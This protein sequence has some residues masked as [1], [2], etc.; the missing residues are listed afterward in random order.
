MR[1]M[2]KLTAPTLTAKGG[3][4]VAV[5]ELVLSTESVVQE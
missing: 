3:Q 2:T 1:I 5:E 4:D